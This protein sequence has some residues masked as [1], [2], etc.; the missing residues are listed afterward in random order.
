MILVLL[1][2]LGAKLTMKIPG[3]I[4]ESSS[5]QYVAEGKLTLIVTIQKSWPFLLDSQTLIV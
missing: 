5:R 3:E 4:H 2:K 1:L